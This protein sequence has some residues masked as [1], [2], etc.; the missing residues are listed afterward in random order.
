MTRTVTSTTPPAPLRRRRRVNLAPV[1]FLLPVAALLL[2]FTL[3]P[4]AQ[5]LLLSFQ[6]NLD[7]VDRYVGTAQYARLLG[8][9]VF[10]TAA[11]NTAIFFVVQVPLMLLLSLFGVSDVSWSTGAG[12]ILIVVGALAASRF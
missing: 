11:L 5:S 7:G 6:R 4:I 9:D 8:D 10:R 2:V 12:A 3:Y 1:L